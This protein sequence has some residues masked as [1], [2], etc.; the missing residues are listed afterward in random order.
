MTRKKILDKV[1]F[2]YCDSSSWVQQSVYGRINGYGKVSREMSMTNREQVM[3]ENY[4]Q[5][6]QM[7]EKYE[8]KWRNVNKQK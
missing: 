7:Q 5:F 4:K 3:I 1:P 6:M 8:Q 2:D